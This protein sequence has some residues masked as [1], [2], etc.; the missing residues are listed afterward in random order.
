MDERH[1][2]TEAPEVDTTALEWFGCSSSIWSGPPFG[3]ANETIGLV[4]APGRCNQG[5]GRQRSESSHR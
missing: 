1:E 5:A 3:R 2:R 4:F